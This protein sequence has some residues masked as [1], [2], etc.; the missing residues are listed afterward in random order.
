MVA[1]WEL[2]SGHDVRLHSPV[3]LYLFRQ[4]VCL[5]VFALKEQKRWLMTWRG[6]GAPAGRGDGAPWSRGGAAPAR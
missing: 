1:Y 6:E 2:A 4:K 3:R 5:S